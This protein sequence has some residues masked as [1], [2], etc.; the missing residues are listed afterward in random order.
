MVL[1]S[2]F[3]KITPLLCYNDLIKVL[4]KSKDSVSKAVKKAQRNLNLVGYC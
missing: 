2:N 1:L 3:L 4:F